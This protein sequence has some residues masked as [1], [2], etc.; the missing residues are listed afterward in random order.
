MK[1]WVFSFS[2]ENF[3]KFFVKFAFKCKVFIICIFSH[4]LRISVY[5]PLSNITL[6]F[7]NSFYQNCRDLDFCFWVFYPWV[8]WWGSKKPGI[9]KWKGR[10]RLG[11]NVTK[12]R[13]GTRKSASYLILPKK[14]SLQWCFFL[15]WP[16]NWKARLRKRRRAN[17]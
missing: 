13:H 10:W 4:V 5:F 16:F 2:F 14:T 12:M 9:G 3:L 17:I 6:V 15:G 8:F 1:C 7:C 11:K